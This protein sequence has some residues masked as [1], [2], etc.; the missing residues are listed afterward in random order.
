[1][2]RT[3]K[4]GARIAYHEAGHAVMAT[5]YGQDLETVSIRPGEA[6]SGSSVT[7]P[8]S[9]YERNLTANLIV[10][11]SGLVAE[12]EFAGE[13]PPEWWSVGAR[14]DFEQI[15]VLVRPLIVKNWPAIEAVAHAL[16]EKGTLTGRQVSGLAHLATLAGRL[17]STRPGGLTLDK[18]T[19]FGP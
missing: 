4:H 19:R 9:G 3:R 14:G 8:T 1:L 18:P 13:V 12:A 11:L 17:R 15:R 6:N 16:L 2:A 5:W 7:L 10:S